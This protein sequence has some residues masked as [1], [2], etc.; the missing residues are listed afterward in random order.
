MRRIRLADQCGVET[1][2]DINEVAQLPLADS[3]VEAIATSLV[4]SD[5]G[6]DEDAHEIL[7]VSPGASD[8]VVKAVYRK[9]S[10]FHA[11][12]KLLALA[13]SS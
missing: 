10:Q 2:K 7:E 8:E 5:D 1:A 6:L 11:P 3:D 9:K 13:P 4:Q 12:S